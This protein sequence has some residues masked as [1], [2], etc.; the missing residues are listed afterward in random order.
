MTS[1]VW[2]TFWLLVFNKSWSQNSALGRLLYFSGLENAQREW[3]VSLP[4]I[5]KSA[6]GQTETNQ[7]PW[8][9]A[10]N[11][12]GSNTLSSPHLSYRLLSLYEATCDYL[13]VCMAL[14]S[15][16]GSKMARH[17]VIFPLWLCVWK[18]HCIFFLQSSSFCSNVSWR[19]NGRWRERENDGCFNLKAA[20]FAFSSGY[21]Y[22]FLKA[23]TVL[24]GQYLYISSWYLMIDISHALDKSCMKNMKIKQKRCSVMA[25]YF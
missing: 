12:P 20:A 14:L 8:L 1:I 24:K 10:P 6:R 13:T 16:D 11:K 23:A 9:T 15:V 5:T 4:G 25:T 21:I 2:E 19:T 17:K 22:I 7:N 3:Q 18:I